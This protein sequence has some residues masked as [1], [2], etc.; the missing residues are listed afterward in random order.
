M[1]TAQNFDDFYFEYELLDGLDAMGFHHPTPIQVM[2][3]PIILDGHD[4]IACAQTGTGKTAAYVLPVLNKIAFDGHKGINTLILVPTR[5]L[6]LQI[7][8]QVQGFSYYID[9]SAVAVFG[10]GDG[11][12]YEQQRRALLKGADIIVSTPGRLIS[13]LV[14]GEVNFDQLKHLILDE[15]DKMLDMGFLEDIVKIISYLP[16]ERQTLMF[17][18]TMPPKIRALATKIM[19]HPKEVSIAIS[20]PA[21]GIDQQAFVVQD[22]QKLKL[23]KHVFGLKPYGS[24]IIFAS[25]KEK[26]KALQFELRKNGFNSKAFHSDLEQNE[27]EEIMNDFRNR[28]IQVLVGTD[29]LSR[30]I[31][32]DGIDLVLNYDVPPDPEDYVHR[33]GRTA[34]GDA[35]SGTAI[36]FINEKDIRRFHQIERLIERV[37]SKTP[38]PDGF[39]PGPV[40]N[41]EERRKKPQHAAP[42]NGQKKK[43]PFFK[44][45]PKPGSN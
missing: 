21:D 3:I 36:T 17:S 38:L 10:G 34:R 30:G 43:K 15:A 44:R 27:R 5:E 35:G 22:E 18:A 2:A 40:Y 25:T 11:A 16:K 1:D 9:V 28:K 4:L 42:A 7:D 19:N 23:L 32:V 12:V 29:I 33:I 37:I 13:Q 31:D 24:T 20:K 39:E 14:T 45:K 41:P 8:Q 26:V 6:A